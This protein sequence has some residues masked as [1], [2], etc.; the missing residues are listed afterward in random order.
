[1]KKL[2]PSKIERSPSVTG[3][4]RVFWAELGEGIDGDFTFVRAADEM[5]AFQWAMSEEGQTWIAR[6]LHIPKGGADGEDTPG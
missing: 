6:R 3:H 5:A 1:M 2:T 4:Y